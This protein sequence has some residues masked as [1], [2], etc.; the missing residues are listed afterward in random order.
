MNRVENEA[1]TTGTILHSDIQ[2]KKLPPDDRPD[3]R[4]PFVPPDPDAGHEDEPWD[5]AI[6]PPLIDPTI[7]PIRIPQVAPAPR[8]EPLKQSPIPRRW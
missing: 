6:H 7:E 5:P 4:L 3:P 2:L 1:V 8:R